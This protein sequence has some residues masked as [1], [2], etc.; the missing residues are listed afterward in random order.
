MPCSTAALP[1]FLVTALTGLDN[2]YVAMVNDAVFVCSVREYLI[3]DMLIG[4]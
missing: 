2:R 4:T 1:A 3:D